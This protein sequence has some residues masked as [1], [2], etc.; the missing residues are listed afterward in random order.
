MQ[1]WVITSTIS[2]LTPIRKEPYQLHKL[3]G[4]GRDQS[5]KVEGLINYVKG[6]FYQQCQDNLALLVWRLRICDK[7]C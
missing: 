3:I 7:A 4:Q 2:P 1:S 6:D 5:V